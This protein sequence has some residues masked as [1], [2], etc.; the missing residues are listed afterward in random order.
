MSGGLDP[1][2]DLSWRMPSNRSRE[3]IA[4]NYNQE[5]RDYSFSAAFARF[6]GTD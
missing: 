2:G 1:A 4:E 3:A 5:I 6:V